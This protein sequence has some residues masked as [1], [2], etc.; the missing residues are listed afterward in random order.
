MYIYI[1]PLCIRNKINNS[2]ST[3]IYIYA[4]KYHTDIIKLAYLYAVLEKNKFT[5]Y[6]NMHNNFKHS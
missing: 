6:L 2:L 1:R 5:S 4:V 3:L